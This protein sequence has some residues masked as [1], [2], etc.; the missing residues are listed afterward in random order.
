[1][2][3]VF[4]PR[5]VRI[6]AGEALIEG[7]LVVPERPAGLVVFAHGSG[8]SRFSRRNRL[9]AHYLESGGFATLLMD[10]LTRD[11]EQIDARTG[12]Y[13]FDIPRLGHRVVAALD[14]TDGEPAV[15]DLA[16]ACFGAS[17]GAAA[18]LIAAAS[19]PDRVRAVI[20]RGGRPDLAAD[21]L[22]LVTAPTLLIV[23]ERD[24]VVIELNR[25]AMRRM[26]APVQLE[27]V[28]RATHLFEEPGT[29]EIVSQLALRWCHR[30]L[31][32]GDRLP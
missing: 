1:M 13:R 32:V 19:R 29:L 16:V 2:A 6:R 23:G 18:A 12:E 10:L 20:S 26:H 21:A 8:S 31:G 28:P 9:V 11:E 4:T 24:D 27:I 14:W 3:T 15:A 7:D 17:T 25:A 5:S 30:H 22:P